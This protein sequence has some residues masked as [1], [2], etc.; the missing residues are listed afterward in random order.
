MSSDGKTCP[1]F[2]EENEVGLDADGQSQRGVDL[3]Q[4][5]LGLLGVGRDAG[6]DGTSQVDNG[7]LDQ[8]ENN[9]NGATEERVRNEAV[10]ADESVDELSVGGSESGESVVYGEL[11]TIAEG[12]SH[13]G[14][15]DAGNVGNKVSSQSADAGNDVRELLSKSD[16]SDVA[17]GSSGGGKDVADAVQGSSNGAGV[18]GRETN[19]KLVK[20]GHLVDVDLM[21]KLLEL[22]NLLALLALLLGL[23]LLSGRHG[24]GG[25]DRQ[26][27]GEDRQKLELHF[28]G[29]RPKLG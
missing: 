13:R 11:V 15:D 6:N 25:L 7:P 16:S 1:A 20:L 8:V 18:K 2:L 19:V 24:I 26:S 12:G 17:D 5:G 3:A 10:G 9:T 21:G 23:A 29:R 4:L 27:G 14:G 28:G 22:V